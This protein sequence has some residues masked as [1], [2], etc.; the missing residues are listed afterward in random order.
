MTNLRYQTIP[1]IENAEPMVEAGVYGFMAEPMYHRLGYTPIPHLFMR[2]GL[3]KLLKDIEA[4]SL[5][6]HGLRFKIW[7]PWR[8]RSLQAALYD[9]FTQKLKK[10]NPQWD[11]ARLKKEVGIYVTPANDAR[12]PPHAT[13]GT[14]DLT[15][16]GANGVDI[17][18]GTKFD[19]FGPEAALDYFEG[20]GRNIKIRDN[21]RLLKCVLQEAGLNLDGD[22]WW[23]Y[24]YGNQK[25]ALGLNKPQAFYGEVVDCELQP[26]KSV[27][28]RFLAA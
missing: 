8:P 18:M 24:D 19:H 22:E 2:V 16:C 1:I 21:R 5:K 3:A 23:H 11:E 9:E 17:D 6:T 14:V 13:G 15:L 26:D 10:E 20:A 12:I 7:D 27:S 25:W 28:C 4:Q